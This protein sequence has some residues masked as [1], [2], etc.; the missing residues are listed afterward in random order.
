MVRG[1][2]DSSAGA[3][4]AVSG[5][6]AMRRKEVRSEGIV[7]MEVMVGSVRGM[8]VSCWD[9]LIIYEIRL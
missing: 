7:D 1:L 2:I 4:F 5:W 6:E 8:P 9:R 3:S